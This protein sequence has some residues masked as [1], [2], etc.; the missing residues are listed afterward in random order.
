MG[1][2]FF[3]SKGPKSFTPSG[4]NL[5]A[6]AGAA[7]GYAAGKA[8]AGAQKDV[9]SAIGMFNKHPLKPSMKTAAVDAPGPKKV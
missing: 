6:R 1:S 5:Q 4:T 9:A 3:K 7:G 8:G 2:S